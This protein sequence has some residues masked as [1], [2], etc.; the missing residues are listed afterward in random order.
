MSSQLPPSKFGAGTTYGETGQAHAL[1]TTAPPP[2]PTAPAAPPQY[3]PATDPYATVSYQAPTAPD[4]YPVPSYPA[5]SPDPYASQYV[6]APAGYSA[7]LR[8][9]SA[10]GATAIVAAILSLIG[11]VYYGVDTIRNWDGI[12][13]AFR[14]L[15]NLSG[16]NLPASLTA[17][18]YGS[19]AAVIAQL[20]MVV[21][22]AVGAI[23]LFTRSA[24][25]RMLVVFGS[26]L[27]IAANA[28]WAIYALQ[29]SDWLDDFDNS[30][31]MGG[32][33]SGEFIGTVLLN[34]GLPALVAGVTLILALTAS[35][36]AW[37][38]RATPVTY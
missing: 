26:L 13:M 7:P 3:A 5:H 31:G 28:Y 17:W 14:S 34:T 15:S 30:T 9:P 16:L 33:S 36:K 18:V 19:A 1:P 8:A 21:L 24:A 27:V 25:G 10:G 32:Q 4:A 29:L 22:L 11:A 23:L 38:S 20:V 2:L 6:M 37:C 12:T 35:T